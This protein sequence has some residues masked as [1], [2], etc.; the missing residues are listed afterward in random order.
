MRGRAVRPAAAPGWGITAAT[1]STCNMD[2]RSRTGPWTA[3]TL[4]LIDANPRVAAS[5]LTPRLGMETAP[6]KSH[7]RK[8]KAL[9]L[10]ISHDTGYTVTSLGALAA[11]TIEEQKEWARKAGLRVAEHLWTIRGAHSSPVRG[12]PAMVEGLQRRRRTRCHEP[13]C[14]RPV[15]LDRPGPEAGDGNLRPRPFAGG[16]THSAGLRAHKL[17]RAGGPLCCAPASA[18]TSQPVVCQMRLRLGG[19]CCRA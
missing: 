7:V 8:L 11:T 14:R 13:G 1:R 18:S 15:S 4:S 3:A 9:G 5:R 2:A 10:T 17:L 6:F 19:F 12:D 16:L